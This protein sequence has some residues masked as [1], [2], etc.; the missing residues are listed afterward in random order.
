[1]NSLDFVAWLMFLRMPIKKI[2]LLEN[3]HR[4]VDHLSVVCRLLISQHSITVNK[5]LEQVHW[6]G[7]G[8][9]QK[10]SR[11]GGGR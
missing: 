4:H 11:E 5:R 9:G 10:S 3:A 7:Q 1:M 2:Q 8:R 6:H